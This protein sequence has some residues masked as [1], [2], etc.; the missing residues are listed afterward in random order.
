MTS[1]A[2][3]GIYDDVDHDPD[4]D[5]WRQKV[6]RPVRLNNEDAETAIQR[7][8]EGS[9]R[10]MRNPR[11]PKHRAVGD[12]AFVVI[13]RKLMRGPAIEDLSRRQGQ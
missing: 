4:D 2:D 1:N 12:K 7:E 6:K 8:N 10:G 9:Y 11:L 13:S 3:Q 5:I